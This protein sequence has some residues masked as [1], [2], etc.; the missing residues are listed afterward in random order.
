MR[1]SQ[2]LERTKQPGIFSSLILHANSWL[3]LP[4]KCLTSLDMKQRRA[5]LF[6][7]KEL[8][9]ATICVHG[10]KK[11]NKCGESDAKQ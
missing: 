4:Y 2:M 9:D 10:K 8:L 7:S 6:D 5:F 3:F 1:D 11:I